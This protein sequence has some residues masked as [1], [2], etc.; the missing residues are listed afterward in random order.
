V[1]WFAYNSYLL[2]YGNPLSALPGWLSLN[3]P[4]RSIAWSFPT[5]PAFYLVAF[6]VIGMFGCTALRTA[7]RLFPRLNRIG[8]LIA[9]FLAL[10]VFD[11]VLEGLIFMPLGFWTYPGGPWP[12]LFGGHY[13]QFPVNQLLQATAVCTAVTFLR[14]NVN[15]RGLTIVERGVDQITG[16][17]LKKAGVRLLAIVAAFHI[18]TIGLYHIPQTFWALNSREWPKDVTDRSYFQNQCGQLAD[19]ACPGPHIPISRPGSG[20]VDWEGHYVSAPGH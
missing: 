15:D 4:G 18:I 2:N 20:Y 13:F 1:P 10:A 19:R 11:T 7:K 12:V 14:Y 17:P 3:E 16:G 5:L 9:G 8:L 6:P